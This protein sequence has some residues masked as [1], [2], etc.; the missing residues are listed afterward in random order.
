MR[1]IRRSMINLK[2]VGC[3]VAIQTLWLLAGCG[4]SESQPQTSSADQATPAARTEPAVPAARSPYPDYVVSAFGAS[5]NGAIAT[6]VNVS[7]RQH[8][9]GPAIEIVAELHNRSEEPVVVLKPFADWYHGVSEAI[10]LHGPEGACKYIG[11]IPDGPLGT[12]A[13]V[14]VAPGEL[15]GGRLDLDLS[16]Y[17]KTE[18]EGWFSIRYHYRPNPSHRG[19]ATSREKQLEV[20]KASSGKVRF[21]IADERSPSEFEQSVRFRFSQPEY[22]FSLEEASQGVKLPYT[23]EVDA[24]FA[25]VAFPQDIGGATLAGPSGLIP[26]FTITGNKQ[27]YSI[28]DIGL[29]FGPRFTS[30]RIPEGHYEIEIEWHGQNWS[31][32][33][34]T[35]NPFGPPFPTGEYELKIR[36]VGL[37][38]TDEGRESYLIES[39]APVTLTE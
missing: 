22:S 7:V 35:S 27:R 14:E 18:G 39:T 34:D 15:T 4:E 8:D 33:S 29:G 32:P 36:A 3:A 37:V 23:I 11:P 20:G 30:E 26:F 21:L 10:E 31:G 28:D 16:N 2:R 19:V 13:F 12:D 24:D 1:V 9:D 5:D 38:D 25:G 17:D 6:R